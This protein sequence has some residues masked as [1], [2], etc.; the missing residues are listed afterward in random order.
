MSEANLIIYWKPK[1]GKIMKSTADVEPGKAY[2]IKV[3]GK[4]IELI[5]MNI[6]VPSRTCNGGTVVPVPAGRIVEVVSTMEFPGDKRIKKVPVNS[7]SGRVRVKANGK[8]A[9]V[10][11]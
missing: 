1:N 11:V 9:L 10:P 8:L 6:E 4:P 3:D 5:P 7:T 2:I